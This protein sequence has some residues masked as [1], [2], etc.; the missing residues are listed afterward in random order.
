[1]FNL[2]PFVNLH[3]WNWDG[4]GSSTG[5]SC[6]RRAPSSA[7]PA[8]EGEGGGEDASLLRPQEREKSR[9]TMPILSHVLL[10]ATKADNHV[11]AT[12]TVDGVFAKGGDGP[13]LE[14]EARRC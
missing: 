1:M 14:D 9:A 3:R 5:A 2:S 13:G 11:S 8:G 12:G 10:E 4:I 6:R 7:G